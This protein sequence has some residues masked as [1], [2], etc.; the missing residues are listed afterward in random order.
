MNKPALQEVSFIPYGQQWIDD[1]DIGAV[2]SALRSPFLTCGPMVDQFEAALSKRLQSQYAVAVSNGTAA[3]H[4]ASKV[5]GLKPGDKVIVPAVTF[6]ATAN[7]V[8]YVGADVIFADVDPET[9]LMTRDSFLEA[10]GQDPDHVKAVYFVHLNG[11]LGEFESIAIDARQKGL[12]VLEDAAHAIGTNLV[13]KNGKKTPVGSCTL[14]DL[15]IFSFHPVKTITM[16]EGG[17]VTTNNPEYDEKL[18]LFRHHGMERNP[19]LFQHKEQ[20]ITHDGHVLPWY[21]EMEEI[22][23]NFRATDFQCALGLSQLRKLDFFV[24]KRQEIVARYDAAFSQMKHLKP[25]PKII[26]S[27]TC[28]HL[29]P[30]LFEYDALGKTRYQVVESLKEKGIGTQVHYMPLP[31]HPYYQQN[32]LTQHIPGSMLYYS[33]ILSIPLYPKMSMEQVEYVIESI[34]KML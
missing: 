21:Y 25:I 10:Y 19:K 6:L 28:F 23:Y 5:L 18:K 26:P 7:A 13:Q 2:T 30:L 12:F 32:F 31:L 15:C 11:Q 1:E 27:E 17:A 29:Y 33:K 24:Q 3:L 22:G 4:L 16:G 14:S 9:G 20:G 8:R 34:A